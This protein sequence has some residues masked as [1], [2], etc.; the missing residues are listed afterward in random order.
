MLLAALLVLVLSF[1]PAWTVD[2]GAPQ[3]ERFLAGFYPPEENAGALFR[4]SRP[5]ARMLLHGAGARPFTLDMRLFGLQRPQ[6][7]DSHTLRLARGAQTYATLTLHDAPEWRTYRVLLPAGATTDAFGDAL[8][9]ELRTAPYSPGMGAD[10]GRRLGVPLDWLRV[11]PLDAPPALLAL[12]LPRALLLTWLAGVV[13]YGLSVLGARRSALGAGL[14]GSALLAWAALN[15]YTLAW[16]LPAVPWALAL[17]TLVLL[18]GQRRWAMGDERWAM[19]EMALGA[20]RSALGL[21]LIVVLALALRLYHLDALPYGLWRDEARHALVA[22]RML[23]DPAYRPIY[24]PR[25]GVHLPGLGLAPFAL[26]LE[27]WGIHIWSLRTVTA[28]AGALTVLPLYA[29]ARRLFG[30]TDVAL[31]AAAFLAVS[32][33]HISLSRF[34]FPTVFDPLLSLSGLWLLLVALAPAATPPGPLLRRGGAA[35]LG[36]VCLGLAA[37]TYHTGRLA[38][39]AAALLV[40][41]LLAFQPQ[42]WRR[43]LWFGAL[44]ALA[45]ALTV[46]PLVGY[47]LRHPESFNDRVGAVFLLHPDVLEARPPLAALDESLGRHLLMFNVRGD[48]NGRHHAPGAPLLDYVSGAGFVV[49]VLLL[50]RGWRDWRSLFVLG[51]LA[52]GLLPSLLAVE[53]PHA[54]RS[55]GALAYAC[56][57]A[58]L[59]WLAVAGWLTRRLPT[60]TLH[61]AAQRLPLLALALALA[62]NTWLYFG[63]MPTNP[64]VWVSFYPVHT[65]VG[66]YLRETANTH[67]TADLRHIYVARKLTRNPV[68]DY[69]AHGLHVETFAGNE[70]SR[71]APPDALFVLSGYTYQEDV[72]HL[73]PYLGADPEPVARGPAFPGTDAPSFVVYRVR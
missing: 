68:F 31:L 9:L 35:L 65:Q 24:E 50:L 19:S 44:G 70:I 30:R 36:G 55:I 61:A 7:G 63:Q 62:L 33:W 46:S 26:A 2:A 47:A 66:V 3:A 15:P 54:M 72:A 27:V 64:R 67:D 23:E 25:N 73:R 11:T 52:L 16:A 53:G 41:L 13:G 18:I 28:L 10:D 59:G 56:I 37:Q 21:A 20:R 39:L 17:A 32:S 12:P 1:P 71:P 51:A 43:W 14:A 29:L 48:T 40:L 34:S 6:R 38:P 5:D 45:A 42:Q 4:W 8:P 60:G 69:L 57:A 49:G 22:L 58:A